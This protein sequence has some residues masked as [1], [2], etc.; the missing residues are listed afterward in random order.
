MSAQAG[1]QEMFSTLNFMLLLLTCMKLARLFEKQLINAFKME[2]CKADLFL[3][4]DWPKMGEI[5]IRCFWVPQI[6]E[7]SATQL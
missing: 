7:Q 6:T 3:T 2:G 1:F 4:S 5:F